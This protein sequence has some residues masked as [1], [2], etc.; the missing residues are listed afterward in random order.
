MKKIKIR[1]QKLFS[2]IILVVFSTT[3]LLPNI[4]R[5]VEYNFDA[6]NKEIWQI[7]QDINNKRASITEL[8]RQVEVY[9]KN[10]NAKQKELTSL[11]N[12]VASLDT[13]IAKINLEV[14]SLELERETTDLK[15]KN[16]ELQIQSKEAEIATQKENIAETL[17]GLHREQQKTG[18]LE[19]LLL[20]ERFSDFISELDRLESLQD[21]LLENVKELEK[22]KN[23]LVDDKNSLETNKNELVILGERLEA[24]KDLLGGQKEVK[25]YLL[26]KTHGQEAKFQQLL[27]QAKAEQAQIDADIVYLEKIAR[28]KLNRK[29]QSGELKS[30]GL[31]WPVPSQIVTAYFHDPD[32][33]YRYIFEHPAIDIRAAQGTAIKAAESGYVAKT[34]DGGQY[35]Y[36]YIMLVH[37]DGLS[38]VYGHVNIISVAEDQFVTQGQIIGYSGGMPG[39]KG[40]GPF[41]SGPHLHFETRVNGIPVNPLNYLN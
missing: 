22:I 2:K 8:N 31:I 10:I 39:T 40:A 24:K 16:T 36:S 28:E 23:S 17:R 41:T 34:R 15:I 37:A 14:Q 30:E 26:E 19:M 25:Y 21:G 7:N 18:V 5:G 29:L 20:N 35:G 1:K 6:A 13:G 11:S 27:A 32:Y 4:V 9:K 3:F 38:T 33:P 12:Q